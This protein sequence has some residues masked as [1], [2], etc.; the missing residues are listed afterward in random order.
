MTNKPVVLAMERAR[1]LRILGV[2]RSTVLTLTFVA[3][4]VLFLVA[5]G[6]V[7][8]HIEGP[9]EDLW[10]ANL[11]NM[12]RQFLSNFTANSKSAGIFAPQEAFEFRFIM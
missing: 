2:R 7:F 11:S 6:F 12:K 10:R 1:R 9:E 4:Y 5:G 8:S 3:S